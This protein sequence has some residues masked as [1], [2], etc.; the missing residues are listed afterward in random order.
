MTICRLCIYNITGIEVPPVDTVVEER[1][2]VLLSCFSQ[3]ATNVTWFKDNVELKDGDK[4]KVFHNNWNAN[5]YNT[6]HLWNN[7]LL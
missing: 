3:L 7:I 1:E 2:V 4:F 5:V 6:S